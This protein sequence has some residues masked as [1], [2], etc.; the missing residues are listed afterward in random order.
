ML[1]FIY[2]RR[3]LFSYYTYGED[4]NINLINDYAVG[5]LNVH[6]INYR[7]IKKNSSTLIVVL[8]E[9]FYMEHIFESKLNVTKNITCI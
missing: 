9:T 7:K 2:R 6:I 1:Y 8:T 5:G 4:V 3:I